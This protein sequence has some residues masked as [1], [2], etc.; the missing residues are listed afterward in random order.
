MQFPRNITDANL[1]SNLKAGK[2]IKRLTQFQDGEETV[3]RLVVLTNSNDK[4][5]LAIT[6]TTNISPRKYYNRDDIFIKANQ[7]NVFENDTYI[8]LNRIIEVSTETLK[9]DYN[10]NKLNILGSISDDLLN[11]IY[12]VIE[13]SEIIEGKYKKR[14][15]EEKK[16]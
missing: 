2:V 13:Q 8:Q 6:T 1:L 7:E 11:K 10:I 3:K 14:I 15:L 12:D 16:I 4:I 9:K 5:T